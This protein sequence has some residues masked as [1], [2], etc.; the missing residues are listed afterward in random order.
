MQTIAIDID[1]VLL[2][3]FQDLISYYNRVY[4]TR[5]TLSDNHPQ[6]VTNWGTDSRSVAIKRVHKFFDTEE[7]KNSKPFAEAKE[8]VKK[9]S[10]DYNLII[11]TAR[12]T[13]IEETT[14][15]WL[16]EHFPDLFKEIHFAGTYTLDGTVKS[17]ADIGLSANADWLIDD[18]YEHILQ[19]SKAGI[20]GILFGDYPWNNK[21]ALPASSV[22]L[23]SWQKVLEHFYPNE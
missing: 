10:E 18:S 15:N 16:N 20:K 4:G 17:K 13:I 6:D 21:Q 12:D 8:A 14:R 23:N 5:L 7:F 2:P 11:I 3:H 19:A 1:E 22:R 9:L